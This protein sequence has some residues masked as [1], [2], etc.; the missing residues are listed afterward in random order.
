MKKWLILAQRYWL[1]GPFS[2]ILLYTECIKMQDTI[3]VNVVPWG[4]YN[5]L[6]SDWKTTSPG[7]RSLYSP[8]FYKPYLGIPLGPTV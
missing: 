5:N 3:Y 2:I 7:T 8:I 6:K 4:I 1:N